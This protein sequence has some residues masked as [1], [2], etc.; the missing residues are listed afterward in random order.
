MV[1]ERELF[2]VFDQSGFANTKNINKTAEFRSRSN[3]R[4]VYLNKVRLLNNRCT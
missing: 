4:Y 1:D 2:K 3:G